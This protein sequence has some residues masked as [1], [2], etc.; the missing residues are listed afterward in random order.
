MFEM[1]RAQVFIDK[2]RIGEANLNVIDEYMGVLGGSMTAS[3]EYKKYR[4]RVQAI[5]ISKGGA[6]SEVFPF[7]IVIENGVVLQSIGGV[8]LI[9]SPQFGE[10][11][12]EI[13][14]VDL[15]NL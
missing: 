12:V 3:P 8:T 14:G 4:M 11:Y 15:L 10:F 6:N 7:S 1:I 5:T 9:D 2:D 13:A